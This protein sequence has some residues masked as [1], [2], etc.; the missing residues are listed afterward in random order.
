MFVEALAMYL[1]QM[2]IGKVGTTI[3]ADSMPQDVKSATMVT[4]PTSGISVDDELR[5]FYMDSMLIVVRD[6]S[7]SAAQKKMRA[8]SDLFPVEDVSSESV[9]FR[10]LRPMTLPIVYPRDDGALF[11]MGL[12]IE[13]AGYMQ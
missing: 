4:S 10:I 6:V 5:G 9:Y 1:V 3:F 2:G 7:L 11:E 12:A 8:I 13:F